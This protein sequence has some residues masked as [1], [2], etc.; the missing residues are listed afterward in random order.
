MI[1]SLIEL[2]RLMRGCEQTKGM[3]VLDHGFYVAR[4]FEDL[5]NHVVHGTTLNY[6]WDLPEWVYDERLWQRLAPLKHVRTYQIMH[7]CGKPA[8][9]T[10]DEDGKVHFPQHALVSAELWRTLGQPEIECQLMAGDMDIHLLKDDGVERFIQ[11]P[12]F[13]TWLL[14]GL[15]E[16]HANASMFGGIDS[17][18]FK[19]K[20]K[21]ISRRGKAIL[22]ALNK[23]PLNTLTNEVRYA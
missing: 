10:T 8:C 6:E 7:D 19:I 12:L 20:H 13:A 9:R 16:I 18:S 23:T 21:H 22:S 14:T 4:Y 2:R 15:A 11:N 3:S 5:R 1:N 17:I